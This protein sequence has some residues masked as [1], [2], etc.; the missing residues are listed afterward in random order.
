MKKILH[1]R[2]FHL[3]LWKFKILVNVKTLQILNL[4]NFCVFFHLYHFSKDIFWFHPIFL[5][6]IR[7]VSQKRADSCIIWWK[8]V[9][10]HQIVYYLTSA[11]SGRFRTSSKRKKNLSR[12]SATTIFSLFLLRVRRRTLPARVKYDAFLN[13]CVECTSMHCFLGRTNCYSHIICT[14]FR[15]WLSREKN[16]WKCKFITKKWYFLVQKLNFWIYSWLKQHFIMPRWPIN[17]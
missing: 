14:F 8:T 4:T 5:Y 7:S 2:N 17:P 12:P 13:E 3:W 9:K 10:L 1:H 6:V 16:F 11:G 15:L